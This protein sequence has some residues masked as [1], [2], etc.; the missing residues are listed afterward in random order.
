MLQ[1]P[2][3][4]RSFLPAVSQV[5]AKLL[6]QKAH[7]AANLIHS[8]SGGLTFNFY[9]SILFKYSIQHFSYNRGRHHLLSEISSAGT[10]A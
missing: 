1:N 5:P 6:V 3:G 4:S 2:F 8:V 9:K 7:G 10:S